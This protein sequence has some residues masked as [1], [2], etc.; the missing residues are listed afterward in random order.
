MLPPAPALPARRPDWRQY[1]LVTLLI[2]LLALGLTGLVVR[3]ERLREAERAEADLHNLS[4]LLADDVGTLFARTESLIQSAENYYL[5]AATHGGIDAG[6]FNAFLDRQRLQVPEALTVMVLGS[7]GAPASAA[8]ARGSTSTWRTGAISS[9]PVTAAPAARS[10]MAPSS[11]GAAR[12]GCWSWRAGSTTR[13]AASPGW[14][15]RPSRP[16][17]SPGCSPS[18]TSAPRGCRAAQPRHGPGGTPPPGRRARRRAG[19]HDGIEHLPRSRPQASRGGAYIATAPLDGV[20]RI[21]SYRPVEAYPFF[22]NIG[23]AESEYLSSW[24]RHSVLLFGLCGAIIL[25]TALSARRIYRSAL[26]GSEAAERMQLAIDGANL[27]IWS[28]DVADRRVAASERC[29][30]LFG[31]P[32]RPAPSIAF[33]TACPTTTASGSSRPSPRPSGPAATTTR[34]TA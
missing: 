20:E 27:G 21:F 9:R 25:I 6:R 24:R 33:S 32:Q 4:L 30:A 5:D 10:S 12:P 34:N 3:S 17:P 18:P 13:T 26:R 7:N 1:V 2:T 14:W 31:L 19:Q 16:K 28:L 23:R 15:W 22:V 29:L 11:P 8:T